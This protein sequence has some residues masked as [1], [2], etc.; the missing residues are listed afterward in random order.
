MHSE[1]FLTAYGKEVSWKEI[2]PLQAKN[3]TAKFLGKSTTLQ[4]RIELTRP[5]SGRVGQ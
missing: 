3:N 5:A 2:S 1:V 4:T